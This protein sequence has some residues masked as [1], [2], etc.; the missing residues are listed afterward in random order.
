M[1]DLDAAVSSIQRS[2][3]RVYHACHVDHV[4]RRSTRHRLSA[5]DSALLSH[6]DPD[7]ALTPSDLARHFGVA[8]STLTAAIQRLEK[9]GYLTRMVNAKDRRRIEL[10]LAPLG[11]E[12]MEETSVLDVK[13]LQKVLLTMGT[14]ER[15]AA[16]SGLAL[17]ARACRD[18]RDSKRRNP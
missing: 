12:A 16:V 8:K 13:R 5:H 17:L 4:R 7:V 6:L 14:K 1:N 10:R 3:P 2:Y 18:F 15:N 11:E 9:L